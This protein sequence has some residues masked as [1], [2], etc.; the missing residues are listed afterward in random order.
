MHADEI[1]VLDDGKIVEHGKHEE[2]LKLKGKYTELWHGNLLPRANSENLINDIEPVLCSTAT[3]K[4]PTTGDTTRER[5]TFA[6][7]LNIKFAPLIPKRSDLFHPHT[8]PRVPTS[9][10]A[11]KLTYLQ[12]PANES[13]GLVT[14]NDKNTQA[15]KSIGSEKL[16][17]H[18][19]TLKP[20]AK[21]FIPASVAAPP[22]YANSLLSSEMPLDTGTQ[23]P[24]SPGEFQSFLD[25][26]KKQEFANNGSCDLA[27]VTGNEETTE[28]KHRRRRHRRRSR[29][30]RSSSGNDH[31]S[32]ATESAMRQNMRNKGN[33]VIFH[34]SGPEIADAY[35]EQYTEPAESG[36]DSTCD[37]LTHADSTSTLISRTSGVATFSDSISQSNRR[38]GLNETT[39][40]ISL[41]LKRSFTGREGRGASASKWKLQGKPLLSGN[42]DIGYGAA[43]LS[44]GTTHKD[45]T[46][47]AQINSTGNFDLRSSQLDKSKSPQS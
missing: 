41:S 8:Y 22:L 23:P 25:E 33:L 40:N 44:T 18:D 13:V 3:I 11:P 39:P 6:V 21:E 20:E 2:L 4:N 35:H 5:P 29:S 37:D 9:M 43:N 32:V 16:V 27:E 34:P 45:S 31:P 10:S 19:S 12:Q 26:N 42:V 28:Q 36:I 47:K 1:L 38:T 7:P 15:S 17:K 30:S 24:V 14:P 46:A